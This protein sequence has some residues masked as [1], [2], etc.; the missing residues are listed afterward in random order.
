MLRTRTS[1]SWRHTPSNTL[2]SPT[3]EPV[4]DC[5]ACVA[6]SERPTLSTTIGLAFASARSAAARNR[7]VSRTVSANTAI[8]FVLSS[9]TR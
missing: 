1:P 3:S 6:M 5:A 8:T 9:S 4:C 7:R 2:S